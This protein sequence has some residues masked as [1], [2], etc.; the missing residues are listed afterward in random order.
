VHQ[1]SCDKFAAGS[2]RIDNRCKAVLD[3]IALQMG[4]NP[5]ATLKITGLDAGKGK[6]AEKRAALRAE[7]AKTYLV[8]TRGV[9][10][11]K[12]TLSSSL[13]TESKVDYA[14]TIP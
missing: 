14:L 7:N 4:T 12:I 10:A 6:Q 13:G 8:K 9:D 2:A 5:K 11:T 3:D 1:F